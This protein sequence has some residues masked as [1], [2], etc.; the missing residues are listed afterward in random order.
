MNTTEYWLISAPGEKT[1]QQTFDKLNQA[2]NKQQLSSNWKFHIPDLKVGTLDQ[3]V[4]LSDDLGKLD[5]FVEQITRKVSNYLGDVLEDQRDKLGENLLAN[6]VDL[7]TYVTQFRWDMAKYPI[8]QSLKNLSDIIS[9]QV[10]QI[11][12]DLKTKAAAYNSLKSN[13]QSIEKKQVGSLVT[14]NVADL[15]KKEHFVLDSEY[16][17]TLLVVVPLANINDWNNKY[18]K[19]TDMIVPRSSQLIYQDNDHALLSV[20]AFHKVVDEFKQKARENK[21]LVRDFTYDEEQLKSGK[22]ELTKLH[23]DKKKQFGPLVRW[24]KVNFGESFTAWIHVKALRV[25]VESVLRFGLPVNFQGMVL[26]P[27]KKQV[28][29][30]R[31]TLNELYFHLDSAGGIGAVEELPSG[32]A[33]FG[34]GDYYPYVYYKMNIDMVGSG[35]SL[36]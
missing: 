20:S 36:S 7:A 28:K 14:R 9:K 11:E 27:Q 26:L 5:N 10:S 13:L 23:T 29:K 1:C 2:T 21:F 34:Q 31:D 30:L 6:G 18:E 15:V 19:L 4:G 16:L 17:V 25:F 35:T 8:K 12:S 22:N 32:L 24:L 33:G 3:L